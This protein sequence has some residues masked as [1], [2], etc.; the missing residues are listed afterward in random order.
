MQLVQFPPGVRDVVM[1]GSHGKIFFDL[2]QADAN[3]PFT[4][5]AG[6]IVAVPPTMDDPQPF[7]QTGCVAANHASRFWMQCA[8][9]DL[10]DSVV[11]CQFKFQ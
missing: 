11:L 3:S 4:N 10:I 8:D 2:K 1:A 7:G 6:D 9:H 5:W